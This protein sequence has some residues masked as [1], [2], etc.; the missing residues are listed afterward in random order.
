MRANKGREG[1]FD[2]VQ[3]SRF[4]L[5]EA[6][7]TDSDDSSFTRLRVQLSDALPTTAEESDAILDS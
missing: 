1:M 4:S 7:M 6:N 5:P 3:R 2:G